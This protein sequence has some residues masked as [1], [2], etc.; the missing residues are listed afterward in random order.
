M[1][2]RGEVRTM[3]LPVKLTEEELR[4]R[5]KKLSSLVQER[6]REERVLDA[7]VEAAK[8]AK[9]AQENKIE[10]PGSYTRVGRTATSSSPRAA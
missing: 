2:K 7:T 6:D 9:K 4:A 10:R 8:E 3:Q 1:E 5:S